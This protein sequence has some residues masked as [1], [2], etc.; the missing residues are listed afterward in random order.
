MARTWIGH[1]KLER[2]RQKGSELLID[3]RAVRRGL[4]A[5]A[6][7]S[8][9]GFGIGSGDELIHSGAQQGNVERLGQH[10]AYT[11]LFIGRAQRR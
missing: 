4:I 11:H 5:A 3:T 7:P 10:D 8:S 6:I 1:S 2:G 9:G